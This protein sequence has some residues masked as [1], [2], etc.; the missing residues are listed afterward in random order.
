MRWIV[1][2]RLVRERSRNRKG[3]IYLRK[4]KNNGLDIL[5]NGTM[6]VREQ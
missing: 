6:R 4:E 2:T 5:K 1:R 3:L